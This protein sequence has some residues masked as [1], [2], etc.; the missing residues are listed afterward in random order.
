MTPSPENPEPNGADAVSMIIERELK[1]ELP[2]GAAVPDLAGVGPVAR[3]DFAGEDVLEATYFDTEGNRLAA[4]GI[5]LRR[6]SGGAD[7]GWHLKLPTSDGH[8]Q[9]FHAPVRAAT[10]P[11]ELADRVSD[12]TGGL[13]LVPVARIDT[14]RSTFELRDQH[15]RVLATLADD[16]VVGELPQRAVVVRWRELELELA[17]DADESLLDV[18]ARELRTLGMTTSRWPSKLKRLLSGGGDR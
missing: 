7:A 9:E 17:K 6:R 4:A 3:Q 1:F 2:T 14:T 10:V 12:V 8:R 15:Q 16:A 5:T 11:E 13:S 18:L